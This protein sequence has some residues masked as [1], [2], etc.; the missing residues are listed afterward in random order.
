M[1]V[2]PRKVPDP[3]KGSM[4]G[5]AA[6]PGVPQANSRR[7][8]FRERADLESQPQREGRRGRGRVDASRTVADP[9]AGR[10]P[11]PHRR[12][13][14]TL[15]RQ[16]REQ[17]YLHVLKNTLCEVAPSTAR[18]EVAMDAMVGPL[19]LRL[20]RRRR[21][22]REGHRRLRQGRQAR[23]Q[24]RRLRRQGAGRERVKALASIPSREV[25]IAQ[26]AGLPVAH[27]ATGGV[28]AA[29]APRRRAPAPAA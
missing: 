28:L 12:P 4:N 21:R 26:V 24:G 17:G 9:G 20:F 25:L 13:V 19:D 10:V 1:A 23:R 11:W 8:L 16:A 5:K 15:R 22:R 18:F 14:D 6:E 3:L 2:P 29:V 7:A 27:P